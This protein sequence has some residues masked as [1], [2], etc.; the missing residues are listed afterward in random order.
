MSLSHLSIRVTPANHGQLCDHVLWSMH[1]AVF[2][3]RVTLRCHVAWAAGCIG[4]MDGCTSQGVHPLTFRL[5]PIG[6]RKRTG[7]GKEK[8]NQ[9]QQPLI[10]SFECTSVDSIDLI[11]LSQ[12]TWFSR[13]NSTELCPISSRGIRFGRF[14]LIRFNFIDWFVSVD[15][16][17][18]PCSG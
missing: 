3:D 7:I 14:A 15:R 1:T 18:W 13:F 4:E 16:F 10:S 5:P 8:P 9:Q 6:K 11:R 12:L 2:S 17:N